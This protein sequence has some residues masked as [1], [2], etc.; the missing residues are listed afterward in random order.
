MAASLTAA[1]MAVTFLA[2]LTTLC[3]HIRRNH[4]AYLSHKKRKLRLRVSDD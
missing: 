4:S 1:I 3:Y 2:A